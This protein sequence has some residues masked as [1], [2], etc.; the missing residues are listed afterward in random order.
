[1]AH[2]RVT[3]ILIH[4]KKDEPGRALE[5]VEVVA[6]GLAGDRRKKAP[7]HLLS[8]QDRGPDVRANIVVDLTRDELAGWVGER[9]HIGAA[10]L[11]VTGLPSGCPGVY[12]AVDVP[13]TVR[14]GDDV[15]NGGPS[16]SLVSGR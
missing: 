12:A 16:E 15:A 14:V 10:T 9:V 3:D 7:V 6:E 1:M 4:P 13:G 11:A 2:G 8:V 5:Y